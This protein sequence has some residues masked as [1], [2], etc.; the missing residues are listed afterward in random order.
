M[1]ETESPM[2]KENLAVLI[3]VSAIALYFLSPKLRTGYAR[4]K[5]KFT[6]RSSVAITTAQKGDDSGGVLTNTNGG[7][8]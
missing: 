6:K 1:G 3:I 2:K 5:S 7:I 8:S 4:V